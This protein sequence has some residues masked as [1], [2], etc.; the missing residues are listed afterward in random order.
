MICCQQMFQALLLL[1]RIL[2]H[3]FQPFSLLCIFDVTGDD[4]GASFV[5]MQ[6]MRKR[7]FYNDVSH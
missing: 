2:F 7:F 1:L 4:K 5:N 3:E 6:C